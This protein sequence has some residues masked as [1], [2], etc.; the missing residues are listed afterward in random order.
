MRDFPLPPVGFYFHLTF[1]GSKT[2]DIDAA[3][4]EVSGLTMNIDTKEI[5][6]GGEN[7]FTYKVPV[8][9]KYENLVLKRG[10][11]P[12]KSPMADWVTRTLQN[13]VIGTIETKNIVITLLD[14]NGNA[15][16]TW[17]FEKAY[18]IK[19]EMSGLSAE[20]SEIIIETLTFS[21]LYYRKTIVSV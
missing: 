11:I 18:P 1:D 17:N 13:G 10:M 12:K 15:L 19:W 5:I 6:Q 2:T 9:A 3:F 7:S 4:Q 8:R 21:Y 14:E 16:C 20:K